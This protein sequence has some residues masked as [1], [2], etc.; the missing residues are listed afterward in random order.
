MQLICPHCRQSL[1]LPN[2]FRRFYNQPVQCQICQRAFSLNRVSPFYDRSSRDLAARPFDRS[3]SARLV[4]HDIR[5]PACRSKLRIP[6]YEPVR[7]PVDLTCP[8]CAGNFIHH[9]RHEAISPGGI[10]IA[11]L[12]GGLAGLVILIL[13]RQGHIALDRMAILSW[14]RD[15]ASQIQIW[16]SQI[17]R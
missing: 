14:L 17:S 5:C 9:A 3:I 12:V 2:M 15:L 11:L 1:T 16:M 13:D 4:N 10:A 6:G 7:S 8:V